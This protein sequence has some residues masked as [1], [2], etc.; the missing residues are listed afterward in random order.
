MDVGKVGK[1]CE[2]TILPTRLR[3]NDI[4]QLLEYAENRID[5][6]RDDGI[7]LLVP[8]H[9]LNRDSGGNGKVPVPQ[10]PMMRTD[11]AKR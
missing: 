10:S 6:R 8:P 11:I 9:I 1:Q 7:S 3:C 4:Y 2:Q 5:A